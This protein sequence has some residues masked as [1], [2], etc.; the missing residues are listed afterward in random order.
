MDDI[1]LKI[2]HLRVHVHR[3]I[4]NIV[5]KGS[6]HAL[7]CIALSP[8]LDGVDILCIPLL[9]INRPNQAVKIRF[10]NDIYIIVPK[11]LKIVFIYII[12]IIIIGII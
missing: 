4:Q 7:Y 5:W 9:P 8:R 12:N 1:I 3:H 2:L 11:L 10:V 6:K